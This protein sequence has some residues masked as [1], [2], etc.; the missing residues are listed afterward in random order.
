MH[1]LAQRTNELSDADADLSRDVQR[2]REQ[3]RSVSEV[4]GGVERAQPDPS[5]LIDPLGL[6]KLHMEALV[7]ALLQDDDAR[8]LLAESAHVWMPAI[9]VIPQ[10]SGEL[11]REQPLSAD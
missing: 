4:R 10:T 2:L 9:G 7:D 8:Q 11:E 3:M 1:E 5:R 6:G